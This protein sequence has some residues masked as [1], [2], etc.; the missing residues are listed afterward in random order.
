MC[1]RDSKI[2]AE[3]GS[4]MCSFQVLAATDPHLRFPRSVEHVR[5]LLRRMQAAQNLLLNAENDFQE[6]LYHL[7]FNGTVHLYTLARFLVA[8]GQS[9]HATEFLTWAALVMESI[10]SLSTVKYLPWRVSLYALAAS[11]FARTGDVTRAYAVASRGYEQVQLL[12]SAA[13]LDPP[14]PKAHLEIMAKGAAQMKVLQQAYKLCARPALARSSP[15]FTTLAPLQKVSV[16]LEALEGGARVSWAA[17]SMTPGDPHRARAG[18]AGLPP[19]AALSSALATTVLEVGPAA[20]SPSVARVVARCAARYRHGPLL[21]SIA[22]H[23]AAINFAGWPADAVAELELFK[24]LLELQQFARKHKLGGGGGGGGG[25]A[26]NDDDDDDGGDENGADAAASEEKVDPGA[27]HGGKDGDGEDLNGDG[28]VDADE[29][30]EANEDR[31]L[32]ST[33]PGQ[34]GRPFPAKE[35]R[36]LAGALRRAEA[37]PDVVERHAEL[38]G[39][40]VRDLWGWSQQLFP[41]LDLRLGTVPAWVLQCCA[42]VLSSVHVVCHAIDFDDDVLRA[43]VAVRLAQVY[44]LTADFRAGIQTARVALV[45]LD[46]AFA[47]LTDTRLHRPVSPADIDALRRL[48][49]TVQAARQQQ[50]LASLARLSAMPAPSSP[51]H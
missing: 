33:E 50:Q 41:W 6:Q 3:Y 23:A 36:R 1:I 22:N 14:V 2:T 42:T 35:L 11:A 25:G 17:A 29:R 47:R 21:S 8:H 45:D 20:L 27:F 43:A 26:S 37:F 16:F 40:V 7:A 31:T 44:Y 30:T 5:A 13:L 10:I 34:P 38:V 15:T 39:F 48:S 12:H 51:N 4:A 49:C 24:C 28:V 9:A 19:H 32:E 46:A 18:N